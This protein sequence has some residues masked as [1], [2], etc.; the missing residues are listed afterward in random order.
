[1]TALRLDIVVL[2]PDLLD[3]Y[4]DAQNAAVLARRARWEGIDARVRLVDRPRELVEY[5]DL[6][7]VGS[8]A[9]DDVAVVLD[10]LRPA[11][12]WLTEHRDEGRGLLAAGLGLDALSVRLEAPDG[13]REGLGVFGGTSPLLPDRASGELVVDSPVGRLVGYENHARGNVGGERW[14]EVVLG[15][16]DG[17]GREGTAQSAMIGTH[18]HGPVLARNPELGDAMLDRAL[19]ARHGVG[20]SA[21][22]PDAAEADGFALRARGAALAALHVPAHARIEP[23]HRVVRRGVKSALEG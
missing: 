21:A 13:W 5:A 3:V 12:G 16:G 7:I 1:M 9:D 15:V 8:G 22:S 23:W 10:K 4:A 19:L 17:N 18:L 14:A 11:T 6:V 20:F 2:L